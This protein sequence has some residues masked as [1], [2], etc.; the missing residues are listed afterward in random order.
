MKN[1]LRKP[2][3]VVRNFFGKRALTELQGLK[4][5]YACLTP[6]EQQV[7]KLVVAG[8]LNKQ[9]GGELGISEITVK[10]YRGKVMQKTKAD[11]LAELV[12]MAAK[13]PMNRTAKA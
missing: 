9:V 6:R 11:S 12:K 8:L 5:R 7:M 3:A 4:E 10:A 2:P 13:L 1:D